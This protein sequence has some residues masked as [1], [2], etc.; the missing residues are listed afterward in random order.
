MMRKILTFVAAVIACAGASRAEM[1][2]TAVPDCKTNQIC[3]Y[4]WPKLPELVG[5]HSD[6][7]VNAAK[8]ATA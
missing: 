6:E 4:W 5:W 1:V 8:A 3:F 7:E 2:K